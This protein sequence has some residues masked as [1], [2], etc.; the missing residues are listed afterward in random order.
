MVQ[1]VPFDGPQ[2]ENISIHGISNGMYCTGDRECSVYH[3]RLPDLGETLCENLGQVV[4]G[5]EDVS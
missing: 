1:Y 3:E 4:D 5:G 2:I